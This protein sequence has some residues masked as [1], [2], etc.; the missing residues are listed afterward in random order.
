MDQ[1]D[2]EKLAI[3]ILT[4]VNRHT[5]IYWT[6][7]NIKFFAGGT[8]SRVLEAMEWLI[9]EQYIMGKHGCI[10][11]DLG[12]EYLAGLKEKRAIQ[13]S[14]SGRF[15]DEALTGLKVVRSPVTGKMISERSTIRSAALPRPPKQATTRTPED[16]IMDKDRHYKAKIRLAK[17]LKLT[18]RQL[19][20][21][22]ES[23]RVRHCK[24]CQSVQVFDSKGENRFHSVCRKCRKRLG[25]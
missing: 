23:G 6:A 25:R 14:D 5:G 10:I 15:K 20:E 1:M 11:T 2:R 9:S 17:T 19:D 22:I 3:S 7:E 18:T 13:Y 16:L 12:F 8:I 24:A 4:V 21:Y